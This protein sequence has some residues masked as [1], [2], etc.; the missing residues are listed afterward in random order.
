MWAHPR[1]CGE[2]GFTALIGAGS[3]GSSPRVRGKPARRARFIIALRLIPAC[4]GK[5]PCLKA[6]SARKKAHPRVCGENS[7]QDKTTPVKTGSSPRVRGKHH[8][9]VR[10]APTCGLIPACAGKTPRGSA[11]PSEAW[12]HPR[13][14]G[15]N[16]ERVADV[17]RSKG[18]S[19]RVRGKRILVGQP[20]VRGGLIPACAGKTTARSSASRRD[21]AHPR[22]CGEN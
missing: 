17:R 16:S 21:R 10:P 14:C 13:V 8:P 4:A 2:N 1:V 5:T 6:R 7:T 15:E 22:V 19:P 11:V 12:A 9:T 20:V 18:S 3:A